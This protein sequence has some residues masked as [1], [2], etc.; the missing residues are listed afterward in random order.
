MENFLVPY[1]SLL[2]FVLVAIVLGVLVNFMI[3]RRRVRSDTR[4]KKV[5]INR[6]KYLEQE[7]KLN[8]RMRAEPTFAV[9]AFV[10]VTLLALFELLLSGLLFTL[11]LGG[12]HAISVDLTELSNL[13]NVVIAIILLTGFGYFATR[14]FMRL[15]LMSQRIE[16]HISWEADTQKEIDRL[17]NNLV[18]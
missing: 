1:P 5:I 15:F 16:R 2:F 3:L 17:R 9:A 6:I 4:A 18:K 13:R 11:V 7:L 14:K 8:E 12:L 10:N